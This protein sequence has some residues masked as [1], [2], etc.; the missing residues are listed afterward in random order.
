MQKSAPI[1]P[2]TSNILPKICQKLATTLRKTYIASI[3]TTESTSTWRCTAAT[4]R[5]ASR[6][7]A[8]TCAPS[9]QPAV[10]LPQ[11]QQCGTAAVSRSIWPA[12]YFSTGRVNCNEF[13]MSPNSIRSDFEMSPACRGT[14]TAQCKIRY[15]V[16][17]RHMPDN[18]ALISKYRLIDSRKRVRRAYWKRKTWKNLNT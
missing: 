1:Q 6:S 13:E 8:G 11:I 5:R 2:K 9:L 7:A 15:E 16:V 10:V 14:I 17:D 3:A 18:I 4:R 12:F